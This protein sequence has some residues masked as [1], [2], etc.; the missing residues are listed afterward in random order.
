[1][2]EAQ[3]IPRIRRWGVLV[4]AGLVVLLVLFRFLLMSD[5]SP[6]ILHSPHDDSLYVLRAFHL[7]NGEGMGPYDSR[8][9]TKLPGMSL[10]LASF[11]ALGLPYFITLN[12]LYVAAGLYALSALRRCGAGAWVLVVTAAFYMLNPF[13]MGVG[14]TRILR[15][16]MSV[17]LMVCLV[18]SMTHLL[19]EIRARLPLNVGHVAAFSAALCLSMLL[20][21][22][23]VLLWGLVALF[24]LA[25]V[26]VRSDARRPDLRGLLPLAMV[27]A[28]PV[29]LSLASGAATRL[30][31][32]RMYG[33]GLL[34]DYSEGEFPKMMAAI[35]SVSSE[36]DNRLVMAPQDALQ[37]ISVEVPAFA[38]LFARLPP[39]GPNTDSCRLQGVC[40]EWSN[41]WMLF[42]MKD[43]AYEAGL[44]PDLASAQRYF[45]EVR[46]GIE[47][48]CASGRLSCA[49]R[50]GG[51]LRPFELRWT[52]AYVVEF[53]RL[54]GMLLMPGTAVVGEPPARFNVSPEL[55]RAFQAVTMTHYYDTRLEHES[56]Q[57]G[58]RP[59]SSSL[60]GWRA[61]LSGPMQLAA[62]ALLL[63][64]GAALLVLG[65][66]RG[67]AARGLLP[68]IAAG[69]ALYVLAR[70]AILAYVA[71][72]LGLLDPRVMYASHVVLLLY[73]PLILS[74]GFRS[75]FSRG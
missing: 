42:W 36:K 24:A 60:A 8:T 27:I 46:A 1:M 20:R 34:H 17:V 75:L 30:A 54:V 49:E 7:L 40:S 32:E 56:A 50:G 6:L 70:L 10:L 44:T 37:R 2:A 19:F 28:V 38:P 73:A 11:R 15:E 53:V 29:V 23:D 45:A 5:L 25:A 14:W 65:W 52:R 57:A 62:L 47:A 66:T 13:T 43:A 4:A 35:R 41:G 18:A 26:V 63:L 33:V 31:V 74:L 3:S 58:S 68:V 71:T 61:I 72:F 9:L 67:P 21:E 64:A 59:L 22:E 69:V 51:L 39:P 55:G 16:P 12:V 48:A